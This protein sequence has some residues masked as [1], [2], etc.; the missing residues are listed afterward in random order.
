MKKKEEKVEKSIEKSQVGGGRGGAGWSKDQIIGINQ[1]PGAAVSGV[2]IS[3]HGSIL[4]RTEQRV[5]GTA[6]SPKG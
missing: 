5:S 6:F 3:F 1:C 2:R 4:S